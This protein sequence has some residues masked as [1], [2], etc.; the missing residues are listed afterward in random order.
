MRD[1]LFIW[2]VLQ[3]S[4]LVFGF[5]RHFRVKGND[6]FFSLWI[7]YPDPGYNDLLFLC[8]KICDENFFFFIKFL[9]YPSDCYI[10]FILSLIHPIKCPKRI[11]LRV[12][13]CLENLAPNS[14]FWPNAVFAFI[15]IV[16]VFDLIGSDNKLS[17]RRN[18]ILDRKKGWLL[19]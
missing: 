9:I 13:F 12:I 14:I 8:I 11:Y 10:F 15:G 1:Y 6:N 17:A 19:A 2:L 16:N 5:I 18:M 4:L 7:I 3:F